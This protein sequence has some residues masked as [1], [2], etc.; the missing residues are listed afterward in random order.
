MSLKKFFRNLLGL[1]FKP[2]LLDNKYRIVEAFRYDGVSYLMFENPFDGS[3]G[4]TFAALHI[5]HEM[6][7]NCD[8][9]YLIKLTKAIDKVIKGG[10]HEKGWQVDLTPLIMMNTYL[11]ERL[12]MGVMPDYV[13]KLASVIFFD[14]TESPYSYDVDYNKKKIEKWKEAPDA[15]D[16]FLST[17]LKDLIPSLRIPSTNS[18]MYFQIQSEIDK[19]HQENLSGILSAK[20]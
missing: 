7:M 3:T 14:Q 12:E 17:P 5:Y 2:V 4:R 19:I 16:F 13:Y 11:K 20:E 1:G 15:L 10:K 18:K 8:R 6:Q 9:D